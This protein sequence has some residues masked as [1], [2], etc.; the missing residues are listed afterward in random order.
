M[1]FKPRKFQLYEWFPEDFYLKYYPVYGDRLW[2]M[3]DVRI[4]KTYDQLRR[5]FGKIV[6]NDWKWGGR[7]QYR[8]WRPFDCPIGAELSQH[9]FGQ[10]G[11]G[12]FIETPICT[13]RS[14]V[15]KG[16]FKYVTAVERDVPW[17]HVDTRNECSTNVLLI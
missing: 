3:L 17:L 13:V 11:D 15:L 1:I 6:M 12:V 10:A 7:N 9:K 16:E 14:A 5:R 2:Q 8:G 4:L